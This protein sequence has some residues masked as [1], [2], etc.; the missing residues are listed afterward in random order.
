MR[1]VHSFTTLA[2]LTSIF[3]VTS[4]LAQD[5]IIL[6]SGAEIP[7]KVLEVA[8]GQIKYRRQDNPEGPV[9][10]T[11]TTNVLLI[12]YANGTKDVFSKSTGNPTG[13]ALT[14]SSLPTAD[15]LPVEN[16]TINGLR[17]HSGFFS[18][19]FTNSTN[20]RLASSTFRSLMAN[21][22]GAMQAFRAGQS[23]RRWSYITAGAAVLL[24]GTGAAVALVDEGNFEHSHQETI[25]SASTNAT[26]NRRDNHDAAEVGLALAGSGVVLGVAA[27]YLR[28]RATVQ[29]RRAADRYNQRPV[30]SLQIGPARRGAGVALTYTF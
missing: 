24:A 30:G 17:Y 1:T 26:D 18:R 29:F 4:A 13:P 12:R 22:P 3:T 16:S 9:Y 20:E 25:N 2:L 21:Q 6:K 5:N 23:L 8:P 28:H 14:T 27:V 7:A 15:T 11:G 19:Y 10:T